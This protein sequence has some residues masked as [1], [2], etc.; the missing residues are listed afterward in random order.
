MYKYSI[1]IYLSVFIGSLLI[2]LVYY[3]VYN[4]IDDILCFIN[5]LLFNFKQ[6]LLF[7]F[8]WV[9]KIKYINKNRYVLNCKRLLML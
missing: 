4:I 5:Y 7:I 3:I 6:Q 2:V 9:I 1:F 8:S